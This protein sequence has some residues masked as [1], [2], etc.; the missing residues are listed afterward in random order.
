MQ[1]GTTYIC[2]EDMEKSL[3]FYK[4]LLQ[5]EP[6][7]QNGKNQSKQSRL[8]ISTKLIWRISAGIPAPSRITR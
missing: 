2:V 4:T 3:A 5:R 8:P 7:E 1:L 6:V